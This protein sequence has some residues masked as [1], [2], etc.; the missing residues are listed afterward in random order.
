[1]IAL[2][3]L[4]TTILTIAIPLISFFFG[5]VLSCAIRK[6][7][8][9]MQSRLG[10]LLVMYDELRPVFGRSRL[11][12]PFYDV[13]KLWYKETVVPKTASRFW[14]CLSPCIGLVLASLAT[15]F[16]PIAGFSLL[17]DNSLSLVITLYLLIG[18]ALMR[19]L[20]ATASSSPWGAIGA[21][22][23]AELMLS[24]EITTTVSLFSAAILANSLS[25][26]AILRFQSEIGL[27]LVVL[28]PF[29]AIGMIVGIVGWLHLKP[30]DAPEA[31]V[32]IVAGTLTEYSGKLLAVIN[33]TR[34][35]LISVLVTLFV[36]TFLGGGMMSPPGSFLNDVVNATIFLSLSFVTTFVITIVHTVMPHFRIDQVYL[37]SLKYAWPIAIS[38]LGLSLALTHL[39]LVG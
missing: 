18:I 39:N 30:F 16:V 2:P 28:N 12:Q 5:A 9:R 13:A 29:A 10:P 6:F 14:F 7:F 19:I 3:F 33:S 23:E 36:D 31:E 26:P 1:M 17:G 32:E 21:R 24:C 22:R 34:F 8:G 25:M 38:S 15:F 11:L 27:P 20:G 35:M 37:W 4:Q